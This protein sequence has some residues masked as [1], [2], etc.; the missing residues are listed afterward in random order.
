LTFTT[1]IRLGVLVA[2][3]VGHIGLWVWLYNR[4]NATGFH[5]PRIK[6]IE[7]GMV[8]IC[9]FLPWILLAIEW[10]FGHWGHDLQTAIGRLDSS[11][12]LQSMTPVTYAYGAAVLIFLVLVGPQWLVHRPQFTTARSKYQ[13]LHTEITKDLH[14]ENPH[15][16]IGRLTQRLLKLPG[17]QILSVETNLKRLHLEGLPSSM[18]GF[19][20][21]HLSDIHLTGELSHDFYRRSLDWVA[22][23]SIDLLVV[24]GDIVDYEVALDHLEPVF[25]GLDARLPKLFVLGNHDRAHGLVV[26]VRDRMVAMGWLDAGASEHWL[27]TSRGVVH[28]MGNELPWLNR[29]SSLSGEARP[30]SPADEPQL[31]LGISHSPDQFAW[32]RRN[33]RHLLLCGH[34]HGGQIRFPWIGPIVAPSWHGSRYASG[35]FYAEPTLMH[36]SRGLSGVHPLRLGCVPEASVLELASAP[37]RPMG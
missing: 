15:W 8:A 28:V 30:G 16:V 29:M 21:G 20:I 13:I 17:N 1:A 33:H 12:I 24:S 10:Q 11:S 23:Q 9:L 37:E 6:R 3:I 31:R 34:T 26:P 32:G 18:H 2:L 5:R 4:I 22:Q 7:K 19:R 14:R 35:V 27:T 25:G 36:V